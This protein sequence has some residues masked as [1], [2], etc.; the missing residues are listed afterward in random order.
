MSNRVLD[1]S[2][3]GFT[4]ASTLG[5]CWSLSVRSAYAADPALRSASRAVRTPA[6]GRGSDFA[7]VPHAAGYLCLCHPTS[8][9]QVELKQDSNGWFALRGG[10][11]GSDSATGGGTQQE[12]P[13]DDATESCWLQP[14]DSVIWS[15]GRIQTHA[16][17]AGMRVSASV[18]V[19]QVARRRGRVLQDAETVGSY[20]YG[21]WRLAVSQNDDALLVTNW[22]ERTT[23][24]EHIV[25]LTARG[26]V[27]F[28]DRSGREHALRGQSL[29]SQPLRWLAFAAGLH[30][31][32]GRTSP[33][34]NISPDLLETIMAERLGRPPRRVLEKMI[35]ESWAWRVFQLPHVAAA[36]YMGRHGSSGDVG[37]QPYMPDA[38]SSS[39]AEVAAVF[40]RGPVA[41]PPI[42]TVESDCASA[43]EDIAAAVSHFSAEKQATLANALARMGETQRKRAIQK[44]REQRQEQLQAIEDVEATTEQN[45]PQINAPSRDREDLVSDASRELFT[46]A[47]E[48]GRRWQERDAGSNREVSTAAARGTQE[49]DRMQAMQSAMVLGQMVDMVSCSP[50]ILI[51][52]ILRLCFSYG[53]SVVALDFASISKGFEAAA[54]QAALD[55]S[56]G[57]VEAAVGWLVSVRHLEQGRS[58]D[59]NGVA[60]PATW[61]N[62]SVLGVPGRVG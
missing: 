37:G 14:A 11:I 55:A 36:A 7:S 33:V 24:S 58:G 28:S 25:V 1:G 48:R 40:G 54:A 60:V 27:S 45:M 13:G 23:A 57:D 51:V 21:F 9:L 35:R 34:H 41:A 15:D 56:D 16:E 50:Q 19:Q 22:H 31:R 6:I 38:E 52:S 59:D 3:D 44:L 26:D 17:G 5:G 18:F 29:L 4:E 61:P 43:E 12:Q 39:R 30:P 47:V 42:A 53:A 32:L 10:G 62:A 20:R 46:A 8:G 2:G 49:P